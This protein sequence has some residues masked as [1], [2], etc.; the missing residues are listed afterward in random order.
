M[1]RS[2]SMHCSH[3]YWNGH[4]QQAAAAAGL[5]QAAWCDSLHAVLVQQAGQQDISGVSRCYQLPD[6]ACTSGSKEQ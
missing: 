1:Q 6:D 5:H 4:R 3:C 2:S